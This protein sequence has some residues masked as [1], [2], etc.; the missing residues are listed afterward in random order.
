MP[1]W[2]R[3]LASLKLNTA[4]LVFLVLILGAATIVESRLGTQAARGIYYAPWFQGLLALFGI[5]IACSLWERW[6]WGKE[7]IGFALTHTSIVIILLGAGMTQ[8]VKIE[9]QLAL[10]EGQSSDVLCR[11]QPSRRDHRALPPIHRASGRFRDRL[12]PRHHAPS[13][14][15]E[16]GP[17]RQSAGRADVLSRH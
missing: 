11:C 3:W 13:A 1:K 5:N 10:W 14:V 7:R 17:S 15:P 2:I 16:S 12:L 6:P 9:G 8:F 4:L